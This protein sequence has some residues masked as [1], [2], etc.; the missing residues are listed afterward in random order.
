M[1]YIAGTHSQICR[2]MVDIKES[3]LPITLKR[4]V[5]SYDNENL[6][7]LEISNLSRS[8]ES[9]INKFRGGR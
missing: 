9:A 5:I 8:L 6:S 1:P 7:V 2:L 3:N 4:H